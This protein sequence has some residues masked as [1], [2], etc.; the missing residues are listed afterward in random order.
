MNLTASRVKFGQ[1][2][3][4]Q[5][6]GRFLR[7]KGRYVD[8]MI[9]PGQ[10]YAAFV[11]SPMAHA[12]I[13]GIDADHAASMPGVERVLTARD[14][15]AAGLPPLPCGWAITSRDGTPMKVGVRHALALDKVRYVGEPVALVVARTQA[16]AKDAAEAVIVDYDDLPAMVDVLDAMAEGAGLIHDEIDAN[17]AFDWEIGDAAA[18][19]AAFAGA[20][21]RIAL[22]LRNNRLVPNAIEPRAINAGW[23]GSSEE[24]TVYMTHQ[25]PIGMRMFYAAA[26]GLAAEH[27]LRMVSPDVGG[28]FGSKAHNYPE[29]VAVTFAAKLVDGPVKWT[30][31][32]SEA[33][34]TDAHGRDHLTDVELALDGQ[35][36]FLAL[37]VDTR[38]NVGAYLSSSGSLVPTYMY[39]TMLSGQYAIPAIHARVRAIYSSTCPVDAYRGA[40]RPEAAY[41]IERI[42]DVAAR[43]LGINPA[44][45]RRRNF[46]REFPYQTPVVY[47]YDSGDYEKSLDAA[48]ELAHYAGFAGRRAESERHGKLRGIGLAAYVEACGIGPSAKLAKLGSGAGMWE[49]AEVRVHP[50]GTVEVL[51]G[52]HSHGQGHATTFAQVVSDR[53]GIPIENVSVIQGDTARVQ[54]GTGTYGSRASV[55]MSA[56]LR[57]C[58]RIIDK[59][60][61]IAAHLM[62]VDYD[63]VE[64]DDG[65][66]S[67]KDS[68]VTIAF[69]EM[70][71]AA[72][73]AASFPTDEIEPGLVAT[74]F[75][76]PPEFTY[77]AGVY[78]CEVEIDP[79]TGTV[80]VA[81]F[82]AADDFGNVANP[83]IVEGQVHGGV[84]QGIGQ[85]LWEN[86]LYDADTGQLMSASFMDYGMPRAQ[87]VPDY[88]LVF[89]GVPSPS[90]P[91][92]MKG[93]G[94]AGAIGAPPAIINAVC[95]ALDVRHVDMPATPEKIWRL[96][97]QGKAG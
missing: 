36:R 86:A 21:H 61:R 49:S 59:G 27:K 60:K 26:F 51:T 44:E 65:L 29:E 1:S 24:L 97:R 94:E 70:A 11:R 38:A 28:G 64:F 96:C 41:V 8:D 18:T 37:R 20:A 43:E 45:I 32:R 46:I 42:V 17:C 7:G 6:D 84:T 3:K 54:A 89:S 13:T 83:M 82:C 53:F 23:D 72:H 71:Y 73:A 48:L 66:F 62:G 57:A 74:S 35:G 55:G 93:C 88:K 14:L 19:E 95:N 78:V 77:P 25:N 67:S 75:F 50:I 56:T 52:A 22:T 47:Q 92:G 58:D 87:G 9:L 79:D 68:N 15:V 12:R 69:A 33:F 91:L 30:A 2:V 85:A 63:A 34:L 76:D 16:Q 40:G 81:S 90:N 39:A 31:D 4:R 5:E 10:L 80:E